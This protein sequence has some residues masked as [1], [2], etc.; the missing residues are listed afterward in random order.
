MQKNYTFIKDE[1]GRWYIDLPEWEGDYEELEM[2][3][4]ADTMLDII[5][6][7]DDEVVVN[8][9]TIELPHKM[10]LE[11]LREDCEGGWYQLTSTHHNFEIWLC[12]VTKFVF[13]NLPNTLYINY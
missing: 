12:H 5:A 2:V 3:Q 9:S 11:F 4:G 10:K 1:E 7:G 6:Q 13:G 8:I